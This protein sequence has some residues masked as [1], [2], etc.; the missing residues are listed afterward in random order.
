MENNNS[1]KSPGC[2]KVVL[3]YGLIATGISILAYFLMTYLGL[4]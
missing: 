3:I 2:M 4:V 1:G